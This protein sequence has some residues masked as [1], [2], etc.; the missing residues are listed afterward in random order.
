MRLWSLIIFSLIL[1]L[2]VQRLVNG[3]AFIEFIV[4]LF[5]GGHKLSENYT[6]VEKFQIY[7]TLYWDHHVAEN[8]GS[9]LLL[10]QLV[11][12]YFVLLLWFLNVKSVIFYIPYQFSSSAYFVSPL[13]CRR[14]IILLCTCRS[15]GWPFPQL[16][17]HITQ[18]L[19]ATKV[20]NLV[21]R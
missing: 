20:S 4:L 15:V 3:D 17:Q 18:E 11:P 16:L 7:C 1:F 12:K 13:Q 9:P 10:F 2:L 8:W 14:D 21:G 6:N 19:F 5:K